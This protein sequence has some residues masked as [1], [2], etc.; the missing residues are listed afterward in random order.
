MDWMPA[1]RSKDLRDSL[2]FFLF[3]AITALSLSFTFS[4]F[5]YKTGLMADSQNFLLT[6]LVVAACVAIPTATIASQHEFQMR[7]YQRQL[8]S[9]ASTDPLTGV[10][11]RR[12]FRF[13]V[14]EEIARQ[15]RTRAVAALALIDLDRFKTI[16][17]RYGHQAGDEVLKRVALAVHAEIRTPFDKFG[18]WGGE[19]FA[20]MLSDV[21][22]ATAQIVLE[23]VR[24]RLERTP[25]KVGNH[26]IPVTASFGFALMDANA[27]FDDVMASA[28]EALYR[29][30]AAGR[31]CI[32][33][34]G[35]ARRAA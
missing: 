29:S 22:E 6:N 9:F 16:N 8:E 25:V 1:D 33:F 23:R 14:E 31:N 19:E 13:A 10:L 26:E 27:V 11:N 21:T 12:F 20:L 4:V 34:T 7:R 17:D 18:R 28:D 2:T 5:V 32:T 15:G 35:K 30:K 3:V 24:S